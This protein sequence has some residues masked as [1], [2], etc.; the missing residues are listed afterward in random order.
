MKKNGF[1]L[2]EVMVALVI[3]SLVITSFLNVMARNLKTMDDSTKRYR[4]KGY[5]KMLLEEIKMK[6]FDER[7]TPTPTWSTIGRDAG[8][9]LTTTATANGRRNTATNNGWDDIDD[10]NQYAET[11]RIV[12]IAGIAE[13][14]G[15]NYYRSVS[16]E[17]VNDTTFAPSA[18][19]TRTKH[20]VVSCFFTPVL[21]ENVVTE[22]W[23][24]TR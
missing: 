16:V 23:Y 9:V 19:P 14:N 24:I 1:T 3:I 17:Y 13:T 15:L 22:E 20:I 12:D 4:A 5:A 21:L 10:Y 8:E 18:V 11:N 6:R 2:V 7:V